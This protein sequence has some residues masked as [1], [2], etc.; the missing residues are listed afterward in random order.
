M[1]PWHKE[2]VIFLSGFFHFH[3]FCCKRGSDPHFCVPCF[4]KLFH[5]VRRSLSFFHKIPFLHYRV[6]LSPTDI[7]TQL[8]FFKFWFFWITQTKTN[9]ESW[10]SMTQ[11]L[12]RSWL[13]FWFVDRFLHVWDFVD[14]R[15]WKE[16]VIDIVVF[17]VCES[18]YCN[19]QINPIV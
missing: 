5:S 17:E 15:Y 3:L 9:R 16:H 13:K 14:D 4:P 7:L 1:V 18:C 6:P 2:R 11:V 10:W 19:M 8:S 12:Y